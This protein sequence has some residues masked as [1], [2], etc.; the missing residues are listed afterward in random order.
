MLFDA[1]NWKDHGKQPDGAW[2]W[3]TPTGDEVVL[4][5][6][7]RPPDIKPCSSAAELHEFYEAAMAGSAGTLVEFTVDRFAGHQCILL[8]QRF[9]QKPTGIGFDY[10]CT[11]PFR[12]FSFV[13]QVHSREWGITGLRETEL[14]MRR[15]QAGE[16]P[17]IATGGPMFPDWEPYSAR[18]DEDFPS[19]P[20]SRARR[21]M[22]G[23]LDSAR[24]D[25]R[26]GDRPAFPLPEK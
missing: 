5:Y 24:L 3:Q 23:I 11:I 15:M 7:N 18:F 20:V 6:F 22:K 26:F 19:H 25:P 4:Y 8:L 13:I 10:K 21:V 9:P 1:S 14:A 17:A 12:D 2:L 16:K